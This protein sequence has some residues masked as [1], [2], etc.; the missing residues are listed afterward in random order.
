MIAQLLR[1]RIVC[2]GRG[3]EIGGGE[4]QVAVKN[5]KEMS[6]LNRTNHGK[7]RYTQANNGED[8]KNNP[9][10]CPRYNLFMYKIHLN[11]EVNNQWPESHGPRKC[12]QFIEIRKHHC[13]GCC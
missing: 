5:A 4:D 9:L 6:S 3:E 7:H 8:T 10:K 1:S 13:Y 12:H 2:G 11:R